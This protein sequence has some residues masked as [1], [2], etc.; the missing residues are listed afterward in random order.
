M[1]SIDRSEVL[2]V[3]ARELG[4]VE[5]A[6]NRDLDSKTGNPGTGNWTKYARDLWAAEPHFYQGPK[7]GYEWCTVFVDWC[8]YMASG[9]DSRR[10]QKALYYTGPYGAGCGMSVRYYQAAGAWH[11]APEP[12][13]QIFFGTA[14]NVRHTGLVEK[15]ENGMVY[16][17][18][19]NSN[20]MVRRR[21]Y[22]LSDS[23]ILGYGRPAYDGV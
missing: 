22:A 23:S 4:Y 19:G 17:I 12:G 8:I 5:K 10:A 2:R 20:H 3:A 18:E 6:S 15:V 7:N 11:S 9:R 21:T 16:T 1:G 14:S 13:D